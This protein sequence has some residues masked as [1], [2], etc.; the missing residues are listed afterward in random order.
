MMTD[1]KVGHYTRGS[2]DRPAS[3]GR[4]LRTIRNFQEEYHGYSDYG[5]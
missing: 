4:A 3:E 5:D 2:K 1:L